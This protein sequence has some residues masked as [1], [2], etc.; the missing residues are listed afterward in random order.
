MTKA[1]KRLLTLLLAMLMAVGMAVPTFA[2]SYRIQSVSNN[3][4]WNVDTYNGYVATDIIRLGSSGCLWT[5]FIDGDNV[6][7]LKCPYVSSNG[8]TM[9]ATANGSQ[10][11]SRI[12][13]AASTL[14]NQHS[15]IDI[16]TIGNNMSRIYF[17]KIDKYAYNGGT[18]PYVTNYNESTL[19]QKWYLVS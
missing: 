7:K 10:A 4:Y 18:Y 6:W 16:H 17:N 2:A 13:V 11:G 9:V 5:F 15:S 8:R 1:K 14:P 19:S 3:T 12:T